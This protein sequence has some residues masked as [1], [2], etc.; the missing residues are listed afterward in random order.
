MSNRNFGSKLQGTRN[1]A[2]RSFWL[3]QHFSCAYWSVRVNIDQGPSHVYDRM[4]CWG[5]STLNLNWTNAIWRGLL[6]HKTHKISPKHFV[7]GDGGSHCRCFSVLQ[8]TGLAETTE[9]NVF[10]GVNFAFVAFFLATFEQSFEHPFSPPLPICET[11]SL[12]A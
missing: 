1:Q 8:F 6:F 3:L 10:S 5:L 11:F 7:L 4:N 12:R 9:E 2:A